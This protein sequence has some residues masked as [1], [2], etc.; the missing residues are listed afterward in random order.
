MSGVI[1]YIKQHWIAYLVGAVI[2][3]LFGFA[4]S[5]VLGQKWSTPAE[6]KA[7]RVEAR[8]DT[9]IPWSEDAEETLGQDT[10][11]GSAE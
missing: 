4:L 2:A 7:A 3:V 9:E 1:D 10:E 6:V 11:N 8:G 5:Y